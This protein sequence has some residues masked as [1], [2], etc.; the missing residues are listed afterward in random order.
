[1]TCFTASLILAA[2]SESSI[3]RLTESFCRSEEVWTF[4]TISLILLATSTISCS[5][6]VKICLD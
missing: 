4:D 1:M 3:I 2:C 6:L 5:S